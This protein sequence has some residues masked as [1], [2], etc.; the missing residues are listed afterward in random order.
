[1]T[2]RRAVL[3]GG[4]ALALIPRPLRAADGG[5]RAKLDEVQA[6]LDA[7]G[8]PPRAIAV[9]DGIGTRGLTASQQLDLSTA[10]AG[11]R[12]DLAAMV[13]RPVTPTMLLRRK[14]GDGV[15]LAQAAARLEAERRACSARADALFARLGVRGRDTGARFSAIWHDPRHAL[16]SVDAALADMKLWLARFGGATPRLIGPVPRWCRNVFALPPTAADLAGKHLGYR[17]LPTPTTSGGYVPDFRP[18]RRPAG[19]SRSPASSRTNCC[20]VT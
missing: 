8:G 7:N 12:V 4:A 1:M 9:L 6:A 17:T 16:P 14:L 10:Y 20:R 2:T 19:V 18:P 5:F 15:D 11:A 3:A 13:A